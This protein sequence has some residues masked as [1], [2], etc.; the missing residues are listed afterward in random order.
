M[1]GGGAGFS[2]HY[3]AVG[4]PNLGTQSSMALKPVA[5]HIRLAEL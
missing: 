1:I 4:R 5:E 2:W 3:N